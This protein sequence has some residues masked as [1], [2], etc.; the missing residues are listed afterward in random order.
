MDL[1][2]FNLKEFMEVLDSCEDDVYLVTDEGDRLNLKSKLMQLIGF[3]KLIEGGIV[4]HAHI[5]CKNKEDEQKLFRF[6][7]FG[8]TGLEVK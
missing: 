2:D 7:L 5:E 8:K 6:N 4:S 1:H 3:T